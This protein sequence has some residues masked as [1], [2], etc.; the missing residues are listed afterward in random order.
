MHW[1]IVSQ[2]EEIKTKK[3]LIQYHHKK[4]GHA[5]RGYKYRTLR[6]SKLKECYIVR[7]ADDFKV[8]CSNPNHAKKLFIAIQRWLKNRLGLEISEDKSKVINLKNE[9][10]EF[11]GIKMKL[12][13]K[14]GK[15][16][17]KSHM[18]NKAK[19]RTKNNLKHII[20]G[21]RYCKGT[22]D[23]GRKIALYNSTIIGLH[24]YFRIATMISKDMGDL[25]YEINA[26]LKDHR[27]DRRIKKTGHILSEFIKKEYAKK[28]TDEIHQKHPISTHRIH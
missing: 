7:Y 17:V 18:C 4:D 28:Q 5:D 25:A 8:F 24:Q 3:C 12:I 2:W 20:K 13:P 26:C 9:Y 14:G 22:N 1:W 19:Q 10:S 27:M 16:I 15:W 23:E 21:I 11:L 6:K